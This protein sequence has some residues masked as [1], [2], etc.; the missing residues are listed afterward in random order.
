MALCH[1]YATSD[2]NSLNTL[3]EIDN[4]FI[5]T[6]T[7]SVGIINSEKAFGFV[8]IISRMGIADERKTGLRILKLSFHQ[9]LLKFYPALCDLFKRH[10]SSDCQDANKSDWKVINSLC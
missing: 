1:E 2:G 9:T 5:L 4:A 3:E 8:G 6:C 10:T 7:I